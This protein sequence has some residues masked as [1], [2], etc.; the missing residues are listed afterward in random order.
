VSATRVVH[1]AFRFELDPNAGQRVLLAKS[2]GARRFVYNW[3]L[4][5]SRREYERL[6]RRPKLAEL[7]ARLVELKQGDCPWLYEVSAHIGQSA[8][9]DLDRAFVRFFKGLKKE[10]PPSGYPRFKK[11]GQRDSA[12]LY[13]IALE[14]RHVRLPMIGRVRVKETRSQ[15][16]FEGR[17]LS[18][19]IRRRA[20]RWF[21]SLRVEV[22][23]EVVEKKAVTRPTDLVGLD[24]GLRSAAIIHDGFEARAVEPSIALR[25]HLRK[26]G[27][28]NRRLARKQKGSRK[29]EK[30]Q[31][32]LARLHYRICCLRKDHLH[33]L[34][35]SLT[36]TKSVIV[37]EDL[38]VKGMQQNKHLALSIGDAS[39]AELRRQLSYKSEWYGSTLI[40]ADRFY[41]SSQLCSRCGAVND[42][43]KGFGGL[44]TRRF[45]C[46]ACSLSLDRDENAALNLRAY[47][48]KELGIVPLPE[49]LR[50]VTPVGEDGSDLITREVKPASQKQEASGKP[51]NRAAE[52]AEASEN[53]RRCG[54]NWD[55]ATSTKSCTPDDS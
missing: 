4:E 10:G 32:E 45:D 51:L 30:A 40:I 15:R 33:Q 11:R 34:T 31:L 26:L 55:L 25:K 43:L 9:K 52:H 19:S 53:A 18:A 37:L 27:R 22:E 2:V 46:T 13:H 28:L 35:S 47:G 21:V 16:G 38:H 29:R 3:G 5:L 42:R 14:E 50:E 41:P 44:K 49:G 24:L 54:C 23:R 8:L 1:Q 48:M 12:R 36:R 17:I 20:D 39:M 7:K 6:G